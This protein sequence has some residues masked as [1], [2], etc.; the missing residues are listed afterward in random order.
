VN[1][2]RPTTAD[3]STTD[4]Q[5]TRAPDG[6]VVF[7]AILYPRLQPIMVTVVT[8]ISVAVSVGITYGS[9][10][11]ERRVGPFAGAVIT[12]FVAAAFVGSVVMQARLSRTCNIRANRDELTLKLG[13]GKGTQTSLFTRSEVLDISMGFGKREGTRFFSAPCGWLIIEVQRRGTRR[14]TRITCMHQ[15]GRNDVARV[16]DVLRETLGMSKRSWP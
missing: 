3:G 6:S 12:L 8:A 9:Y 15:F 5:I 11:I 16:A 4:L 1:Q 10:H 13:L 14:T 2:T 7:S